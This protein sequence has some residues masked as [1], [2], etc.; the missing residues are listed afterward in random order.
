MA[1]K[2]RSGVERVPDDPERLH[3]LPTL[4]NNGPDAVWADQAEV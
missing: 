2:R 1:F 3:L 4:S